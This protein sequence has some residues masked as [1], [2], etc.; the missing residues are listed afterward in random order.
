MSKYVHTIGDLD[1]MM[2]MGDVPQDGKPPLIIPSSSSKP[3]SQPAA[4]KPRKEAWTANGIYILQRGDTLWGLARTYLKSGPRWKEIW[5]LQSDS[6]K[7]GG[8]G[9]FPR[10][11]PDH[12]C[13]G[14]QLFM[15]EEAKAEARRLGVLPWSS[16]GAGKLALAGLAVAALGGVGYYV[17]TNG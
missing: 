16:V 9:P 12:V 17:G 13:E 3:P 8:C 1:C 10:R 7:S 2:G 5:A 14:D 11:S 6:W 15:P 4:V